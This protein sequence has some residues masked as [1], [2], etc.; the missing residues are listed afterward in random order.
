L[1]VCLIE[2]IGGHQTDGQKVEIEEVLASLRGRHEVVSIPFE[3]A[4]GNNSSCTA[5]GLPQGYRAAVAAALERSSG[6]F[7]VTTDSYLAADLH[8]L[9]NFWALTEKPDLAIASRFTPGGIYRAPFVRRTG[10]SIANRLARRVLSL[11]YW[12]LTS[13]FRMYRREALE[14]ALEHSESCGYEFLPESI[15]HLHGLGRVIE[16]IPYVSRRSFGDHVN[17]PGRQVGWPLI[18][19]LPRLWRLRNSVFSADYDDRAFNSLIW[20]QRYWQRKRFEIITSF[21][22]SPAGMLDIGCGSSKIIQAFPGAIGLDIQLKK[23]RYLFR[24]RTRL[25]HG[26]AFRLPFASSSFRT[27]ICSEVI[28]H[29]PFAEVLFD[30]FRR[31]LAPNGLLILGTPDYGTW[32]WPTIEWFY[33]KIVPGGYAHEHITHY[34]ARQLVE[35]LRSR[36]FAI[37]ESRRICGAELIIKARLRASVK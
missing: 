28:E 19:N 7:L 24:S 4:H 30:E 10:A 12:D 31:V 6:D 16:E 26:S 14:L 8:F 17:V 13:A 34:T 3:P 25:V 33:G 35:L 5:D 21:V 20:P 32:T 27:V 15:V 29:I 18:A 11:P 23:L 9:W 36:G 2:R 37:D 22:E 1:S